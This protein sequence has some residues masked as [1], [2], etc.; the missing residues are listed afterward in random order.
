MALYSQ[1]EPFDKGRFSTISFVTH[2]KVPGI[3][4]SA[5]KAIDVVK[6]NLRL[7]KALHRKLHQAARANNVSLN[8][9]IINQLE[10]RS[11]YG[12]TPDQ[13]KNLIQE[14]ALA[15]A[16]HIESLRIIGHEPSAKR[17]R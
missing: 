6:L 1:F 8:T 15:T 3:P 12:Q 17:Q 14:T 13:V 11:W 16:E 2:Q 5:K 7:P 10:A 4:M 9:E